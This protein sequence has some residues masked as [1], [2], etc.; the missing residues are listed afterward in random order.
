MT[1][2][3][4][5]TSDTE[6]GPSDSNRS[7]VCSVRCHLAHFLR[8]RPCEVAANGAA[9]A[10][11]P[12]VD[13]ES[14]GLGLEG[15]PQRTTL[16]SAEWLLGGSFADTELGLPRVV[17]PR[18]KQVALWTCVSDNVANAT[19]KLGGILLTV[20]QCACGQ[21]GMSMRTDPCSFCGT[22]RCVYCPVVKVKSKPHLWPIAPN[23]L[24][25]AVE[26][27]CCIDTESTDTE[28]NM[29]Q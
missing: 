23:S 17:A 18:R 24:S 2:K 29:F 10:L 28:A 21:S 6:P 8:C 9:E 22:P 13:P 11:T 4:T 27:S 14:A 20:S 25:S 3:A 19:T 15:E 5:I 26:D 1:P 12:G 16:G 7:L